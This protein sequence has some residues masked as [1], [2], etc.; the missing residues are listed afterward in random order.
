MPATGTPATRPHTDPGD[1][2]A[3]HIGTYVIMIAFFLAIAAMTGS[4]ATWVIWIAIPWGLAVA[5]H[6]LWYLVERRHH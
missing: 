3:Y 5:F 2:L 4:S 6:L 1:G